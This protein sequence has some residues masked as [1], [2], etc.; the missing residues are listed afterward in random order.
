MAHLRVAQ[1]RIFSFEPLRL[2]QLAPTSARLGFL[3]YTRREETVD[4]F[5]WPR[6]T[7]VFVVSPVSRPMEKPCS[8]IRAYVLSAGS[9]ARGKCHGR[10]TSRR[11]AS[12]GLSTLSALVG[13]SSPLPPQKGATD[14]PREYESGVVQS[15]VKIVAANGSQGTGFVVGNDQTGAVLVMTAYH[16]V[17]QRSSFSGL[18]DFYPHGQND[19]LHSA[20]VLAYS[21]AQDLALLRVETSATPSS[22]YVAS[23]GET[24]AGSSFFAVS[25][26][27]PAGRFQW[28]Y[29]SVVGERAANFVWC[30]QLSDPVYGGASGSPLIAQVGDAYRVIGVILSSDAQH[31]YAGERV[32]DFLETYA[33]VADAPN[34]RRTPRYLNAITCDLCG[35][36]K[37]LTRL[38]Y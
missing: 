16:V 23:T 35:L 24:P 9:A 38:L 15:V 17:Q 13:C 6:C 8:D 28:L 19:L 27:F 29:S 21:P 32:A 26:G 2:A 22:L 7:Y 5:A 14:F 37:Q 11:I 10:L 12:L 3:T 20:E 25:F 31:A 18:I 1:P 36:N 33:P 34:V 30:W 4:L